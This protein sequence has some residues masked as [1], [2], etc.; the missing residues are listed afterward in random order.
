MW[1]GILDATAPTLFARGI[2]V[3]NCSP[4][5]VLKAFQKQTFEACFDELTGME[6]SG[7]QAECVD[8]IRSA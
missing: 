4:V 6:Q 3:I 5:S 8:R 7:A 2:E 1:R